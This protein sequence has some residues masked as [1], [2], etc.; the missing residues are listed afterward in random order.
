MHATVHMQHCNMLQVSSSLHMIVLRL[1][2]V[3]YK[4]NT[5]KN[6]VVS[7]LHAACL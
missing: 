5:D 1:C 4:H 7:L 6:L 2:H 3:P